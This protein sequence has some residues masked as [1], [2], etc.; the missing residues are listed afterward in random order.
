MAVVPV[1]PPLEVA[2]RHDADY[3]C[4]GSSMA[5]LV[6]WSDGST[7][8]NPDFEHRGAFHLAAKGVSSSGGSHVTNPTVD[9]GG[10]T[11]LEDFAL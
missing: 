11:A 9:P 3:Y 8:M 1:P 2:P 5:P 10:E 6:T 7:C 4:G